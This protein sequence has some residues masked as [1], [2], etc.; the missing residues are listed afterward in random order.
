LRLSPERLCK[1][2][3]E[4]TETPGRGIPWQTNRRGPL[5]NQNHFCAI[6]ERRKSRG[7]PDRD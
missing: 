5:E 1:K 2:P 3:E 4:E 7:N 6:L